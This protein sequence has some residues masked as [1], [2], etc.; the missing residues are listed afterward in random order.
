MSH[1]GNKSGTSAAGYLP[2]RHTVSELRRAARTCQGCELFRRATQTVFGVGPASAAIMVVGEVPGD[3]EDRQGQ[4]FVGPAG[5]LLD[6][7][8]EAAGVSRRDVYLT[9][10][11]KHFKWEPRGS[12]RLHAKPSAREI[13]ACHP[14]LKAEIEAIQPQIIVCLGAT[15]AQA[16]LGRSFRL[17][18]HLGELQ[19]FTTSHGVPATYHPSAALRA[20]TE[21]ERHRLRDQL[22]RDLRVAVDVV[23]PRRAG[24]KGRRPNASPSADWRLAY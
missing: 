7:G 3:Q 2:A 20:P 4:P 17:T 23:A 8:L 21:Q 14:W 5:K 10:A 18:Q 11:V 13:T 1:A 24:N 19:A 12:R 9:N 6:E 22:F 16:L 15:A